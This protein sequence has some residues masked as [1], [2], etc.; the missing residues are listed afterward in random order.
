VPTVPIVTAARTSIKEGAPR[1]I[2]EKLETLRRLEEAG[3][4]GV[5]MPS[6]FEQE[7]VHDETEIVHAEAA[8]G[9]AA[10]P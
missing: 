3:A 8:S 4:A 1:P 10:A 9:R 5:V 2:G 7:L 6:L